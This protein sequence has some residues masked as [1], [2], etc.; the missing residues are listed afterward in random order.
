[1]QGGTLREIDLA[2]HII[3]TLANAQD[4]SSLDPQLSPDGSRLVYVQSTGLSA[5]STGALMIRSFQEDGD[6]FG[7]PTV[8]VA[9]EA[10]VANYSPAW[11][12]DGKWLTFT[13]TSGWGSGLTLTAIWAV[14]T[15]GSQA[16]I[17]LTTPTRDIDMT[18]RW[19]MG[20][21][22]IDGQHFY[23]L[24]FDSLQQYGAHDEL[25]RQIWMM[26]FFPETKLSR[27]AFHV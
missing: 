22:T 17:Q 3:Q 4:A 24:T 16:P 13:R 1:E 15:D 14:K 8:L 23:Y 18:A 9:G 7:E 6:T 12:P 2:G 10:G 21:Q 19:A 20:D 11:S 25:G 27:P 26:A 5:T